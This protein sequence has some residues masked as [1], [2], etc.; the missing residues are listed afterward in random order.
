M[1]L[2]RAQRAW[3]KRFSWRRRACAHSVDESLALQL[4]TRIGPSGIPGA[5]LG[6][7]ALAPARRGQFLGVDF[8]LAPGLLSPRELEA[9]PA[10][11]RRY[12]WRHIETLYFRGNP[13]GERTPTELMNHCFQ[14]NVLC[15]L[16]HYF[17]LRDIQVGDELTFDYRT[18]LDPSWP[19]F[20]DSATGRMVLGLEWRQA[21]LHTSRNLV[22]LLESSPEDGRAGALAESGAPSALG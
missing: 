10:E 19:A 21:L 22:E 20:E 9:L 3:K 12:V 1:I 8:P 15:H 17:A 11:E 18:F 2:G 6:V 13:A 14:A 5:G 16:G 4:R 7:F